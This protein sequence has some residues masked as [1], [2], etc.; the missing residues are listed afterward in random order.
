M[1]EA[2]AADDDEDELSITMQIAKVPAGMSFE[3][4]V[5]LMEGEQE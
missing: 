2:T 5:D 1:P 4:F 3:D